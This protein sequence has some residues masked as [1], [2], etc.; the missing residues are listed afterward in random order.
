MK[1]ET[2]GQIWR[3]LIW[4][5][6]QLCGVLVLLAGNFAM[7]QEPSAEELPSRKPKD[8]FAYYMTLTATDPVLTNRRTHELTVVFPLSEKKGLVV[9]DGTRNAFFRLPSREAVAQWQIGDRFRGSGVILKRTRRLVI[10]E[11]EVL[12]R[13]SPLSD[14]KQPDKTLPPSPTRRQLRSYH[15]SR[16]ALQGRITNAVQSSGRLLLEIKGDGFYYRAEGPAVDDNTI[17]AKVGASV[18]ISGLFWNP[19]NSVTFDT[20]LDIPVVY[21]SDSKAMRIFGEP[22]SEADHISGELIDVFGNGTAYLQEDGQIQLTELRVFS[23]SELL[24]PQGQRIDCWGHRAK[25]RDGKD[26]FNVFSF[27]AADTVVTPRTNQDLKPSRYRAG[28]QSQN[29]QMVTVSGSLRGHSSGDLRRG[30][31]TLYTE[32]EQE[33]VRVILPNS[34]SLI[35]EQ[36]P[37]ARRV[38]VTGYLE[39]T[40]EVAKIYPLRLHQIEVLGG[41]PWVLTETFRW[42]ALGALGLISGVFAWVLLLKR[43]VKRRTEDLD[44]SLSLLNASYDAVYEG[45]CVVD[46]HGSIRKTNPR[47]W[48]MLGLR[49]GDLAGLTGEKLGARIADCFQRPQEFRTLWKRLA[50]DH[51]YKKT[52]NLRLAESEDGEVRFYS[53]PA[54]THKGQQQPLRVWVFQ[55]MTKQRHLE[56]TLLQSQKMEA[57]GRLAGGVAH[58][59]NN[60]LTGILGNLDAAQ[61][62]PAVPVGQLAGPL[63]S[64]G[65]AARRAAELVKS[66]LGFSRQEQLSPRPSCANEVVRQLTS[67]VEP[68]LSP[69]ITLRT[70]LE[71]DLKLAAFDPTKLEQV[72]LNMVVNA[73]DELDNTGGE[74]VIT[75][76]TV[77]SNHPETRIPGRYVRVCV[78]DDGNGISDSIRSRIFEPFFTTKEPGKG[79]GLGLATSYGIIK[80]MDGWIDCESRLGEGTVFHV[81]LPEVDALPRPK[82]EVKSKAGA[83]QVHQLDRETIEVLCVDDEPIVR[84][85]A[86]GL[87]TRAGFQVCSAEHG[88]EALDLLADRTAG[89]KKLPDIIISDLT[90]PVMDGK[91]LRKE[92]SII[93]PN[94][95]VVICSGYMV[96]LGKFTEEVGSEF[97]GFIQKPYDPQQMINEVERLLLQNKAALP[98]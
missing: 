25:M 56:H 24:P 72:I 40:G 79:T 6:V 29:L 87:L 43:E 50:D 30:F 44:G 4:L 63:E 37:Q 70:E 93:H 75:T 71:E 90:M 92:L 3:S 26:T 68:T 1:R 14:F 61:S 34:H 48:E 83:E 33:P 94:L 91:E 7:A 35:D 57:V 65:K 53:V 21:F 96:D 19:F 28:D 77:E 76:Q 42:L 60:L 84:R 98:V 51:Q 69:R 16:V 47:F 2:S 18:K 13:L 52:G 27:R 58:D 39:L 22:R 38:R 45:I 89:G 54:S 78:G 80:Q 36:L 67:L 66:L 73:R 49:E 95:P 9:T 82:K 97:D 62:D 15:L 74:I 8:T 46:T 86:E 85:V 59:F 64:A 88:R 17:F 11:T 23:H 5:S 10:A 20:D 41:T 32:E 12:E 55:D 31:F 81:Y